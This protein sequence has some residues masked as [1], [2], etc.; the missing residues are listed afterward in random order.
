MA[1]VVSKTNQTVSI[2]IWK[3]QTNK[4]TNKKTKIE[5]TKKKTKHQ[6]YKEKL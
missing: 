5:K 1:I 2:T 4:Q 3:K 6:Q